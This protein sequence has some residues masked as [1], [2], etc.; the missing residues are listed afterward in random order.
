MSLF[1]R[2]FQKLFLIQTVNVM[3]QEIDKGQITVCQHRLT[4]QVAQNPFVALLKS[5]KQPNLIRIR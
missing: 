1:C 3:F 5:T 4:D 2:W